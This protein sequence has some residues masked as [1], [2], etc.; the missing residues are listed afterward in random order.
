MDLLISAFLGLGSVAYFC[1][2]AAKSGNGSAP[3]TLSTP[4]KIP[5]AAFA[6]GLVAW[7]LYNLVSSRGTVAA[8][9]A[10]VLVL[11]TIFSFLLIV[12]VMSFL[13]VRSLNPLTL[14]GLWA[15]GFS[16]SVP[17]ALAGLL[18]A[19]PAIY[20]IH[21]LG[22]HFL[23]KPEPQPLLQFFMT[24]TAWNDRILLAFTAIVVAPVSEE[25]IFR[26]YLYGVARRFAG[27]WWALG[28][29]AVI[30]AAIHAHVPAFG[31][32][33]VLAVALTLVYEY[34]ASLWAPMIMHALFNTLTIAA[35]LAWPGLMK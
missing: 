9:N 1:R 3:W 4:Y 30:F 19:L 10:N 5:D 6:L 28:I 11:N 8:V 33:L 25:V 18:C 29:S 21:A 20:F 31:G 23:G 24:N 17:V 34:T 22:F 16:R 32:L 13:I 7:F 27:R 26:G 12:C 14:F 15:G 2:M 35:T